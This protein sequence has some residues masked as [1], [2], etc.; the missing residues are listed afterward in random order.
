[1]AKFLKVNLKTGLF[2][3]GPEYRPV[4]LSQTFIGTSDLRSSIYCYFRDN[5]HIDMFHFDTMIFNHYPL[6]SSSSSSSL[7]DYLCVGVFVC[8]SASVGVTEKSKHKRDDMMNRHAFDKMV[9]AL[10]KDKQVMIFVHSRKE[11]SKTA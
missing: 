1:V 9:A 4:P 3:F 2:Y 5:V 6:L 11:T 8:V 7:C 10:E